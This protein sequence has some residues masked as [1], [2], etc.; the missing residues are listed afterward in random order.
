MIKEKTF[1][2]SLLLK[3]LN[4]DIEDP[5]SFYYG[6]FY[7]HP[8]E[9]LQVLL[10]NEYKTLDLT[11]EPIYE[12]VN[13]AYNKAMEQAC[14]DE[15]VQAQAEAV[16]QF[17][18]DYKNLINEVTGTDAIV[19]IKLNH[20]FINAYDDLSDDV[21]TI[22]YNTEEAKKAII[23]VING[24]GL[25]YGEEVVQTDEDIEEHLFWLFKARLVGNIWGEGLTFSWQSD[26]YCLPSKEYYNEQIVENL[27]M[28]DI[29]D[30]EDEEIEAIKQAKSLI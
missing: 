22:E 12:A 15:A 29:K 23:E 24:E 17:I 21:F 26:G 13:D 1:E 28:I 16:N 8:I 20:D 19:S 6:Y 9:D 18:E 2:A 3:L 27:L 10:N 30:I 4:I 5:I 14:V 25:F 7:K 11:S